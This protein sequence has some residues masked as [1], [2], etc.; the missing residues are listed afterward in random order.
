MVAT[1]SFKTLFPS[2]FAR[3]V[4]AHTHTLTNPNH[5]TTT[6]FRFPF[7]S[8][9]PESWDPPHNRRRPRHLLSYAPLNT[10]NLGATLGRPKKPHIHEIL[11][12][13]THIEIHLQNQIFWPNNEVRD[14]RATLWRLRKLSGLL[15][16]E[17]SSDMMNARPPQTEEGLR[18]VMEGIHIG[19]ISSHNDENLLLVHLN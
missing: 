12:V 4:L 6:F 9:M 5:D 11:N 3:P 7:P 14:K 17:K 10:V 13:H 16:V 15:T 1:S 8:A 19:V 18:L 2:N